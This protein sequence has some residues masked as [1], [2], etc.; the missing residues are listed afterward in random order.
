MSLIK[1]RLTSDMM[2]SS[3]LKA[4]RATLTGPQPS[5]ISAKS[6]ARSLSI[7][8]PKGEASTLSVAMSGV[9]PNEFARPLNRQDIFYVGSIKNLKEFKQE[10]SNMQSYRGS[11]LSIPRSV[12]GQ[13]ISNLSHCG[14]LNDLGSRISGSRLSRITGGLGVEDDDVLNS[15]Y[16]SGRCKWIPISIRNA[17]FEMIDFELL[18]DPIMLKYSSDAVSTIVLIAAYICLTSIVLSDLLGLEKLTNSFGLLVVAR[19]IASLAGSPFADGLGFVY[20]TTQSY[21]AAFFFAGFVIVLS[22][23]IS[24]LIPYI[25]K[26]KRSHGNNEGDYPAHN[27]NI[28]GK[29]SVLTEHSEENLTEYQRTIQSLRQQHTLL[30]E[31]EEEKRRLKGLEKQ[32]GTFEEVNEEDVDDELHKL[33]RNK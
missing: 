30:Q 10:G 6:F 15:F 25:H 20:D 22:G 8:S 31:M 13:T 12:V 29:L 4:S 28:S 19:G 23:L 21:S 26:W 24:C 18:E 11:I 33:E 1:S 9:D 32:N 17:F 16:D 5:R 7:L 27:D 14:E 2:S 3:D